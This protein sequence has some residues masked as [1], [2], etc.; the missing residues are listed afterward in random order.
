MNVY[1]NCI[2]SANKIHGPV[3]CVLEK[4]T[5]TQP[6]KNFTKIHGNR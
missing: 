6:L 2:N 3:L 1:E 4:A 5:V